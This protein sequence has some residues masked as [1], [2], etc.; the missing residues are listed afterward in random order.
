M[1]VHTQTHTHMHTHI[2]THACT[3]EHLHTYMYMYTWTFPHMCTHV[4]TYIYVYRHMWTLIH[5]YTFAGLHEHRTAHMNTHG[6]T[7][8]ISAD[9][10]NSDRQ[11][12]WKLR[13]LCGGHRVNGSLSDHQVG[14]DLNKSDRRL[15]AHLQSP[16]SPH[17]QQAHRCSL[18]LMTK[19]QAETL[20]WSQSQI[21][22]PY[23]WV[24]EQLEIFY[25]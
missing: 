21:Q 5:T 7:Q 10:K 19:G 2:H 12:V 23:S 18:F 16:I 13:A 17:D 24:L 6:H 9:S 8:K 4:S 11:G 20:I 15:T 3:H 14:R 22:A 25:K 1:C